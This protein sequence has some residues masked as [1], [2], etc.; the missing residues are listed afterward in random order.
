MFTFRPDLL[1]NVLPIMG[2]GM[3]GVF[4]VTG[5]IIGA[6]ALLNKLSKEK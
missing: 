6:V 2:I 5:I 3:L 4:I 1:M